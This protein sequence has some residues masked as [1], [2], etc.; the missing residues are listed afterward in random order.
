[1]EIATPHYAHT[2]DNLKD[3]MRRGARQARMGGSQGDDR[4]E[5]VPDLHFKHCKVRVQL[6]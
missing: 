6:W 1:M 2:P 4:A 3:R 5:R